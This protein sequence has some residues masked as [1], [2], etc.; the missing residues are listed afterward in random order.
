M[1]AAHEIRRGAIA[2]LGIH[3]TAMGVVNDLFRYGREQQ[4]SLHGSCS[5]AEVRRLGWAEAVWNAFMRKSHPQ[6]PLGWPVQWMRTRVDQNR[7]G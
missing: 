1:I 5:W 2:S 4:Q 3:V 7:L 6:F